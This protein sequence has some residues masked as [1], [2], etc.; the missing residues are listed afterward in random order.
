MDTRNIQTIQN[1]SIEGDTFTKDPRKVLNILKELT[2]GNDSERCI[3]GLKYARKEM[4]DLQAH[5]H[6]MSEGEHIK[7]VERVDLKKIFN[8]NENIYTLEKYVTKIKG[9]FNMVEKYG[10][11]IY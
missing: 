9:I 1:A 7:Q 4:Q 2:I 10:V 8:K 5:Y 11:N 6:G 3:K